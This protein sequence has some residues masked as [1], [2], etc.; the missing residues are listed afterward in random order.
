MVLESAQSSAAIEDNLKQ[1]LLGSC[2]S[3][4]PGLEIANDNKGNKR[5]FVIVRVFSQST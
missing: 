1:F 5:E 2:L 3:R 4:Y